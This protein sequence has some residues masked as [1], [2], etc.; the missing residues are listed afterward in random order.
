ML[1]IKKVDEGGVGDELGFQ[2]GDKILSFDGYKT[3]DILDYLFYDEQ[4]EFSMEV[5]TSDGEIVTFDIEKDESETLGLTF[6]SDNLKIKTCRNNCIFCFVAQMPKGMRPTLYVKDDDY[7]QSFLCGNYVTLTN[8]SDAD[9]E[10]I[11]RLNLSPLYVSVHTT[12]SEVRKTMLNNRF[13]G[14]IL[15]QLKRL[16]DGGITINTQIVLVKGVND[17]AILQKSLEDLSMIDGVKTCAVVPC[18]IT[19]YREWLAKIED[20]NKESAAAVIEVVKNFNQKIGRTFA[21]SADDFY[22]KAKL[23][24]EPFEYYGDF[25]QLENG[26]GMNALFDHDF[27]SSLRDC[28]KKRTCLIVTGKATEDFI[29]KYAAIVEQHCKGLK[30]YVEGVENKFFGSTV[31]C[32]GLLVGADIVE[33]VENYDKSFDDLV[34]TAAMLDSDKTKFLD[35]LTLEQLFNCLNKKCKKVVV[36]P[37]DGKGFFEGLTDPLN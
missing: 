19:R 32:A 6:V 25:D 12:D 17:G 29:K 15:E 1:T 8:V 34:I 31:T 35:D 23:P 10:R 24:V 7:R 30:L 28:E 5:E 16:S 9:I 3:V 2:K 20:Y 4:E 13:A 18:G 14:K 22:L 36:L 37:C 27:Y 21:Y 33:F 11:I 26:I